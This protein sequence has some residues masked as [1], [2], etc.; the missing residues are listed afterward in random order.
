MTNPA[1]FDDMPIYR[2]CFYSLYAK[3]RIRLWDWHESLRTM[4]VNAAYD[5]DT[6]EGWAWAAERMALRIV[7][8]MRKV[9]EELRVAA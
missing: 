2:V 6:P 7:K 3:H 8:V 9:T 5:E 1:A 4:V